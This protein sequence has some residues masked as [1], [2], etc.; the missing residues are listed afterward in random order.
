MNFQA[1]LSSAPTRFP[2]QAPVACQ[3]VEGAYSQ[4]ACLQ[5]FRAPSITYYPTFES[6]FTAIE[7]GEC[8]YGV[9]PIEN[10]L[11][12]SV[13]SVYAQMFLHRFH[14]VRSTTLR[15]D[16]TLLALPGTR[17]DQVRDVYSHEQGFLQCREFLNDFPQW[18][19]NVEANTAASAKMVARSKNPNKAA[20]ASRRAAR[21]YGLDILAEG[22]NTNNHNYTRF[23]VV[24]EKSQVTEKANKVSVVFTVPHTE[25]SLHRILS[26]FAANGLNLLKLESRPIPGKGWEYNFF[27]DFSGNLHTEGMEAVVH[28]LIDETLSFRILG[29]YEKG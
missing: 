14:I 29:N 17:M 2:D 19:Q 15:I 4:Q 20:I 10:S 23:V 25:G 28:Q 13:N 12:G 6:V 18:N 9:L 24:A 16:P 3:G 27:A 1:I 5:I 7:N 26:V 21:I 8:R 11:A 22:I